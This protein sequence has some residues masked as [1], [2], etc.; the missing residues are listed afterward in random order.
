MIHKAAQ[1]GLCLALAVLVCSAHVGSPDVW[2]EG[3]AGPYPIL[4]VV[5]LPGV[6]PGVA[7]VT[8]RASGT[9][10]DRVTLFANRFDATAAAPPPED[11][12]RAAG[13]SSSFVGRL[14]IM[15]PGSNSVTVSAY[16]QKGSGRAV[17]PVVAVSARRLPLYRWLGVI[18]GA[19][20][21]FLFIGAVSIAGSAVREGTLEPGEIPDPKRRRRARYAM[22]GTALLVGVMLFGGW[23]WW[24][25][26]DT[27]FRSEMYRPFTV[28]A[29]V[30]CPGQFALT[31]TDSAWT[32]RHDSTWLE[33]RRGSTRWSVMIPDHGKLM[34]LFLV[35]DNG[36]AFA[37]LHPSTADTDVFHATLP[38]LPPGRY[39]V[40]ADVVHESG[41]DQTLTTTVDLP[42]PPSG[43]FPPTPPLLPSGALRP[44]PSLTPSGALHPAP[45]LTPSGALSPTPFLT[46]SGALHPTPSLTP[47]GALHPTP[48]LTPSGALHPA[49]SLTPSGALSP[50]P[51]LPPG[52][53]SAPARPLSWTPSDTDDAWSAMDDRSQIR[54]LGSLSV[55]VGQPARLR[56]VVPGLQPYMGMAGHAVVVRDDGSVFIHLHPMGTISSASQMALEMRQPGDSANGTLARR[57]AAMSP[58]QM[59]T[60]GD[61]VSFPYAFPRAG[62]YTVWVQIKRNGRVLT[63]PFA[64]DAY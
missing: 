54:W 55:K 5:R 38:P 33:G 3:N 6:V 51:L 36:R 60:V 25:A 56:F 12:V 47:S 63:A 20:G 62:H 2:Y 13:D 39:R 41:F 40:F 46:P 58:M 49:P 17:V 32:R 4:V 57:L 26:T 14:W 19:I 50:T 53:A 43:A 27:A 10:L 64:I 16:G 61:T 28:R 8:V 35:A 29:S 52:G 22:A 9:P 21:L 24:N 44:T 23:S 34:H 18:L 1:R 42:A 15:A 31:I 37:H 45:S 30:P 7:E 59:A 11:A 48:S